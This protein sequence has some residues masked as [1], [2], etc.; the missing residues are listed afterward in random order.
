MN[1]VKIKNFSL[2][3]F[4]FCIMGNGQ[5]LNVKTG[6]GED[7]K[8]SVTMGGRIVFDGALYFDDKTPLGNGTTITDTRLTAKMTYKKWDVKIDMG[9]N[10]K[11][12]NT[13]D[14]HLKY[15]INDRSWVKLGYYGEQFGLENWEGSAWQKF[16]TASVSTQ[17]FG[18]SRQLGIT[19]VNWNDKVYYSGGIFSDNDAIS[20]VKE[21]NQG[22][23][24]IGKLSYA[25]LNSK[26]NLIHLGISAEYRTGNRN[27]VDENNNTQRFMNYSSNLDTR[28]EKK[29]PINFT[30]DQVKN[31][32]RFVAEFITASGPFFLQGEYYN[33][34]V[35][36]RKEYH[37]YDAYGFYAQSGL[38]LLGDQL[39]KYNLEDRRLKRPKDKTLELVVRY[40]YTDLND[41]FFSNE[42]L[43]GG[44]IND[45][46]AGINY[47]LNKY[48]GFKI[49]Y[50]Y[51]SLGNNNNFGTKENINLL[52][53]RVLVVF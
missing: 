30:L 34:H 26:K 2:G 32:L 11:K 21:G 49:N 53:G 41:G 20:D 29:K 25:P 5:S 33:L 40:D 28:V 19:Y 7:D 37:S 36:R 4:L 8:I 45:F 9:F 24:F 51:L 6:E 3:L 46:S 48:I 10:D 38:L 35:N 16:M 27:G 44:R 43:K 13:K 15:N 52:Q 31:Q 14:L 22:Y 17:V 18:T 39:Y 47:Y 42:S 12:V 50:S 1:I 23:A